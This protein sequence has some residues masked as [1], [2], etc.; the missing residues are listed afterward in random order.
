VTA[1]IARVRHSTP[2]VTLISPPPHHD[3]YSIEAIKQLIYDL[4]NVNPEAEV[5]VKL[6]SELGVGTVAAGVA[7]AEA[8]RVLVSGYDGGTGASPLTSIQHAGAPWEIGLAETQQTLLLNQLRDKVRVQVDGQIKTG[9]DI[10]VGALLGAEEF[11]FATGALVCMGCV[12]MRKCHQNTCPVGVATQ[13]PRLRACF[14][15]RPEHLVNYCRFLAEDVR[16]RLAALGLRSLD[17][18]VGRVDLL[19]TDGAVT[20]WKARGLDFARVFHRPE[21]HTPPRCVN[22]RRHD[23]SASLDAKLLEKVGGAIAAGKKAEVESP[24][25]NV[26]RTVGTLIAGQIARAYG[27]RGLPDNTITLRFKGTAGRASVPGR[28]RARR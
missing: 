25:R 17:E 19:E 6:V 24:I 7:K 2:G 9:R 13:D 23:L 16:E 3:I 22:P 14:Q 15:G 8:D 27:H 18:A 12:M 20:F 5:S 1:E 4:R 26:N 28:C 10:L 21:V 11:G